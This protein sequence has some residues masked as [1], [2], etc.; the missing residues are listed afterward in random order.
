MFGK[1]KKPKPR[2]KTRNVKPR[3]ARDPA[4]AARMQLILGTLAGALIVLGL[5]AGLDF[6]RNHTIDKNVPPIKWI[7]LANQPDWMDEDTAAGIRQLISD[8]AAQDPS[9]R[10]LPARATAK[11]AQKSLW[12]KR[13]LPAGVVNDYQG[14]LSIRCEFRKPL[15]T[16][17]S[18]D[19]LVR[20]DQDAMVLPGKLLPSGL[21][22][23]KYKSILGVNSQPPEPGQ[24]WD[25]PDL[26]AAVELLK[27]IG[28]QPFDQEIIAVNVSN[29]N[30]RQNA[31]KSHI[32][33]LT[34]QHTVL[35]WGRA[36][37]TEG[38]IEVDH[39][40][41]LQ[42][43]QGLFIQQGSLNKLRYVDLRGREPRGKT[44]NGQNLETR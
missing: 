27:L 24:I 41:K 26:L 2:P 3:K 38:H 13:V 5:I 20:V 23:G 17:S 8:L 4:K 9:D 16:V 10:N 40:Q 33:M 29:F 7:V 37:G 36:I 44:R 6:L 42:H 43:L 28:D 1:K 14:T 39:H 34:D 30:G 22:V 31:S 19:F 21:P 12:V 11:L 25:A 15:A 32:V 18:G 35:N